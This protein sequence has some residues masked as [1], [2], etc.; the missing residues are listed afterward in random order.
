MYRFST[1]GIV[2]LPSAALCFAREDAAP[3][4][5]ST[6]R[7]RIAISSKYERRA[8]GPEQSCATMDQ[9]CLVYNLAATCGRK[10]EVNVLSRL[11]ARAPKASKRGGAGSQQEC[12]ANVQEQD[13]HGSKTMAMAMAMAIT[14]G[15]E[16]SS[17][18]FWMEEPPQYQMEQS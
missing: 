2:K 8:R 7:Q 12:V 11:P 15:L 18:V 5:I 9:P 14:R 10:W 17:G 16:G 13:G 3:H 4:N 6:R 1:L